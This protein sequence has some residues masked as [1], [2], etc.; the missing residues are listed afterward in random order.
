MLRYWHIYLP[1]CLLV[2]L[3]V[4]LPVCLNARLNAKVMTRCASGILAQDVFT[5]LLCIAVQ[6]FDV[7]LYAIWKINYHINGCN[8]TLN[9][10][11]P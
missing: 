11:R 3:H 1:A 8:V 7:V 6:H 2:C 5:S 9:M 4:C 10:E